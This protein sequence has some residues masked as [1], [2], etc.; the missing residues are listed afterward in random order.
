VTAVAETI[1][2]EALFCSLLQPSENPDPATVRA[3]VTE[4]MDHAGIARCVACVAHE[5]GE[6]PTEAAAR[7]RWAV[8]TVRAAYATAGVC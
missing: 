1:W 8:T 4:R 6:H 3:A 7:M 2:A 5:Y